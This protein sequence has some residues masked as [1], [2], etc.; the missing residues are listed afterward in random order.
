[1]LTVNRRGYLRI[2]LERMVGVSFAGARSTLH[3]SRDLS[4]TG[5]FLFSADSPAGSPP[6][7]LTI[8]ESW[9][10]RQFLLRLAGRVIRQDS[11][12]LVVVFTEMSPTTYELLQTL[13]LYQSIDPSAMGEEFAHPC[14][15]IVEDHWALAG[16][17]GFRQ[18]AA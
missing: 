6:C 14:P 10:K 4:L 7:A 16:H 12:G 9:A 15:F 1:M 3:R 17:S 5:I 8:R 11:S 13:L 18:Q 2:P